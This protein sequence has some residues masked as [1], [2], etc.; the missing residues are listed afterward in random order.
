G[1]KVE[2]ARM[3]RVELNGVVIHDNVEL[4]EP[5]RGAMSQDEKATGPLRLQGDHGAVAFRNMKIKRYDSGRPENKNANGG[6]AVDPILV[7]APVNTI[8][9][10][11]MDLPGGTRL[12]HTVSVGS[13]EQVHYTYDMDKGTIVQVWRGGFLDATPMWHSRG[14]GSS[15]PVGTVQRFGNPVLTVAKLSSPQAAWA[16]DTTGSGY[17]PKG[18]VLD[19]QDRPEFRYLI[20]GSLVSDASRA[21]ENGQGISRAITIQNPAQDMYVRLAEAAAIEKISEG[22]YL[23][24]NKS[25]YLRLDDT[26]GAMPVIR[27]ANGRKELIIP[28]RGKLSYSIL[29]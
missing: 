19:N 1:Q 6:N 11:F 24:D 29:F 13:A 28:I 26:G 9:R 23:V 12:V 10:S 17:R 8:L 22:M 2:N 15:R 25:Y 5:T 14:D 18:Y 21:L 16:T 4:L 3:L 20:Y 27:D 7:N